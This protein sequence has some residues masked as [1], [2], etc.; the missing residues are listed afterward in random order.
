MAKETASSSSEPENNDELEQITIA[1]ALLNYRLKEKMAM[2]NSNAPIPF[3]KKFQF[4][5]P[6]PTSPQPPPATTSKIL[7]L[8]CQRMSPRS[9]PSLTTANE[10]PRSRPLLAAANDN[11]MAHSSALENR[12]ARPQKFPAVGA[13]PYVPIRQMRSPCRGIAPPVTIRSAVPVFSAPPLPPPAAVP[14][15]I[16]RAP[17]VRVAPPVNIRQAIPVYAAPPIRKDEP[18]PIPKEDPITVSASI[19]QDKLPAKPEETDTKTEKIIPASQTV[20]SLEQ[21]KI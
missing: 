15:Q 11:S 6:R 13:A 14:H 9:R 4:Q 3:L 16:I 12:G 10:S 1:R 18:A 21:L 20:Q 19:P 17:P 5:N 7:P 8:I 2:S